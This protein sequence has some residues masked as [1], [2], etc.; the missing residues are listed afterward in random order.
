VEMRNSVFHSATICA[1]AII[2]AGTTVSTFVIK[3]LVFGFFT[4]YAAI[5]DAPLIVIP[6]LH[7]VFLCFFTINVLMFRFSC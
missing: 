5:I 1:N 6:V 7:N 3:N 4:W 2:H